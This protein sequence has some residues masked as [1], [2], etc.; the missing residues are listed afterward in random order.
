MQFADRV[1]FYDNSVDDQNAQLL[2][3]TTDGKFAKQYVD[4]LP[5][6]T[7]TIT[8]PCNVKSN[9]KNNKLSK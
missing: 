2:F 4:S 1:Y 3:R 6:L 7:E 5:E 9:S 8:E